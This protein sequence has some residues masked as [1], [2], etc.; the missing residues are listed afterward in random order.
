M[1]GVK[2]LNLKYELKG[3]HLDGLSHKKLGSIFGFCV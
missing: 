2:V 3:M 1:V